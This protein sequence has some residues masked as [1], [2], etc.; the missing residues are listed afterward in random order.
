M[1]HVIHEER[2]L[3]FFEKYLTG[4]VVLC[5]GIGIALDKLFPRVAVAL[6]EISVY[7]VSIPIAI[8]PLSMMHPIMIKIDFA[9]VVKAG[10]TP[11]PSETQKGDT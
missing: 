3:S 9:E 2:K 4:W 6:D 10:K 7:Q 8:C 1:E 11:K 5:I